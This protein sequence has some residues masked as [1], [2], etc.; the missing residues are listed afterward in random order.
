MYWLE[1]YLVIPWELLGFRAETM[2]S[3]FNLSPLANGGA[4]LR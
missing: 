4:L 3:K 1:W 2:R